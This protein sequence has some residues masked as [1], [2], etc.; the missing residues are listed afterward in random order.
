MYSNF[1]YCLLIIFKDIRLNFNGLIKFCL[2]LF[3]R[4]LLTQ[5]LIT[6]QRAGEQKISKIIKN[7][8]FKFIKDLLQFSQRFE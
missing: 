5:F 6:I 1:L 3:R 2:E 4:Y 8:F 7:Y